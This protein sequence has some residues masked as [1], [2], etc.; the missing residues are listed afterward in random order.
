MP[1]LEGNGPTG[2]VSYE[3]RPERM[4][5]GRKDETDIAITWDP[6]VSRRHAQVEI[7]SGCW[8]VSDLS[9]TN[10][11]YV[12]GQRVEGKR[13][14]HV[15]DEL[16]IGDTSL[17]LRGMASSEPSPTTSPAQKA[18]DLTRKQR[19]VLRELCRPQAHDPRS[20]CA[21]TKD[22]A[23]RMFVGEAAVKAHLSPLYVKFDIPEA[24]QNRR[25]LL[26]QKA[27]DRGA[28]RGSDFDDSDRGD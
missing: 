3:L 28:V 8:Y 2:R 17:W 12:N 9:A 23:V 10:G 1:Y 16:R 5:I 13:A 25:A 20:P 26:A 24:G 7:V 19:E 18:P 6:S 4:T 14:L 15:D 22:I 21:T 27:W 11:T